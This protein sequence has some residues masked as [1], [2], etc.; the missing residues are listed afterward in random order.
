MGE[1][2]I[3]KKEF[4]KSI[5]Q[6]DKTIALDPTFRSAIHTK[7]FAYSLLG[8]HEKAI[9]T[10][11]EYRKL[12]ADPLKGVTGLGA[13]YGMMGNYEKAR[14][15]IAVLDERVKRDKSLSLNGDYIVIYN[16]MGEYDKALDHMEDSIKKEESIFFIMINPFFEKVRMDPRYDKF[17]EKHFSK[18]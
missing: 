7:G 11:N 14:E 3:Y 16:S 8:E 9:E 17:V 18:N 5:Q 12:L 2:Y 15:C 1:L 10:F 6:L 4:K 13:A